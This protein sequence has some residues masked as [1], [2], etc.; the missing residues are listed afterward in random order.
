[1]TEPSA[2]RM[3]THTHTYTHTNTLT[4]SLTQ[5]AD[6]ALF[7]SAEAQLISKTK[8]DSDSLQPS[9]SA[10]QTDTFSAAMLL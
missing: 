4:H 8:R 5:D 7:Q 1:M 3:L 10:A 2:S 6:A 9:A